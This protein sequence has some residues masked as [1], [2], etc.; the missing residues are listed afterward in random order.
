MRRLGDICKLLVSINEQNFSGAEVIFVTESRRLLEHVK[1]FA[2][3]ISE[4]SFAFKG[5]LN[6]GE[7]GVNAARNV[8]IRHASGRVIALVD[9]D[10][11]LMP[12]WIKYTMENFLSDDKL[13]GLTGPAI[14]MWDDPGRMSWFPKELYFVWG[15]TVWNWSSVTAI[16]NVG[17]M[18]CS[19]RRDVLV[20]VGMYDV[21]LGPKG[22]EEVISWFSPSGEEVDLSL[23]IRLAY[24]DGR[25]IFDPRVAVRHRAEAARFNLRFIIKRSFRLGY[26]KRFIEVRYRNK[27]AHDLLNLERGHLASIPLTS[28]RALFNDAL[29]H[30]VRAFRRFFLTV[31]GT[32]SAI[33]GYLSYQFRPV[34]LK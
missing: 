4:P 30:P 33:L 7:I 34:L 19:F 3:G 5:I 8:G 18:N 22:G 25:I 11:V 31:I 14:P 10:V 20:Q 28:T 27:F 13:V 2:Q 6:S 21:N 29:H 1:A 17:G 24:P 23:R 32:I 9:D 26:T 16:R 12:N 15:C